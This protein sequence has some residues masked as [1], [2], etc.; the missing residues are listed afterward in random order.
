MANDAHSSD[1]HASDAQNPDVKSSVAL[2][3]LKR[4]HGGAVHGRR[5]RVLA[6]ALAPKIPAGSSVLDIGCGDGTLA[7]LVM[8][9]NP[10]VSI[11]GIEFAP[12]PDCLI[13]CAAFD[14]ATIPHP[15]DSFDVCMFVD[16]LHHAPDAQG[17]ARLLSEACRVSRRYVLIKDHLSESFFDFKTLQFMDWV[18]NRPHGVVLPY[19]YQSRA[20]WNSFFSEAGLAIRDWN[21]SVP[22]YPFPFSAV[23]GRGLH[24]VALLEK[25]V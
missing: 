16:V 15:A 18:G 17:I 2:S 19:N 11:R 5:V 4:A 8:R 10:S 24:F 22:L 20:Q 3:L 7:G 6:E 25:I 13:E 12:R 9:R 23:F 1:P 21:G 14:G